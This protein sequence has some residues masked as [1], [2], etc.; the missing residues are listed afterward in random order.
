MP[1]AGKAGDI[2]GAKRC[3]LISTAVFTIGSLL[4]ALAPNIY[5]LIAARFVQAIGAGGFL[6]LMSAIASD[7]FP[8]SRQQAI[9]LFSSI[10]PIGMIIGPNIGGWLVQ[11]YGWRSVFWLNIPLGVAVFIAMFFMLKETK[12]EGGQLDLSGA[13]L[14]TGMLSAFLIALSEVGNTD[15]SSSHIVAGILFAVAVIM[16]F[17]FFRHEGKAK[18]PVI[19]L[20]M[21]KEKP[22]FAANVFNF[23]YGMAVLGLMGFIPLFATSIFGMSIFESGLILTPRSIGMIAASLVTSMML[24]KW[25]YRWPMVIGIAGTV[26]CMILLGLESMGISIFGADVSGTVT[27][28]IIMLL[29]GLAMG[30]IAPAANNACIE[31]LPTRVATITGVR[32]MFR[33]SGSAVSIAVTALMLQNFNNIG[34][35]FTWVFYG[36]TAMLVIS[37]PFI[38]AM[39]KSCVV[40]PQDKKSI[41]VSL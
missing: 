14:F 37:I 18:N 32:G 3:F 30:I 25:G 10:F 28:S 2:F 7:L 24:P 34:Q 13:G 27:L 41:K 1:L 11:S 39:P 33:Q 5:F 29:S 4:S 26:F 9:G 36:L 21:L 38:F 31:L 23:L 22:F 8:N 15:N 19:D 20:Q 17:F 16:G 35:G 40:P 6:P 12:R